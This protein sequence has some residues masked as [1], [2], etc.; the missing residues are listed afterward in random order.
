MKFTVITAVYNRVDTIGQALE[1]V[2]Q[3]SY[4]D[5]EHLVVDGASS[6]GTLQAIRDHEHEKMRVMSEPDTGIYD[7]LNKGIS[8]ASGDVIGLMHSDDFFCA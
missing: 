7:A 2:A 1:S 3:Q 4:K 5:V 8:A 6:D